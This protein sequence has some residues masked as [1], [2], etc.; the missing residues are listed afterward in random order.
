MRCRFPPHDH[1]RHHRQR[2]HRRH[3]GQAPRRARPRSRRQQLTGPGDAHRP[4]RRAR[5]QR[6]R[7]RPP[8]EAAEAGEIVIVSIPFLAVDTVPVAPLAGKVVIDTNNYYFERDGHVAELDDGVHDRQRGPPGALPESHVVKLFNAIHAGHLA[9]QGTPAGTAG[10]R[11]LPMAGDDAAAKATV[12]AL[13]DEIG[14]DV[15]DAG[16]ARRG[17]ALRPR[18]AGVRPRGRRRRPARAARAGGAREP[19]RT[20]GARA[21]RPPGRRAGRRR[22]RR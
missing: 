16:A 12:A 9:T 5:G 4:G 15:V 10:R 22:R 8:A 6:P 20:P 13:T 17:L 14:Y 2:Q 7:R 11:A 19:L 1:H 21:G 3:P 18:P